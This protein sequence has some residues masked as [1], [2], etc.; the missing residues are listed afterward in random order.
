MPPRKRSTRKPVRQ[1]VSDEA[2]TQP[3]N[4]A[5]RRR[6]RGGGHVQGRR[7]RGG[8]IPEVE[9][10]RATRGNPVLA[11]LTANMQNM[12]ETLKVLVDVVGGQRQPQDGRPQ[13]GDEAS[14]EAVQLEQPLVQPTRVEVSLNA[15]TKLNP[16]TFSGSDIHED[17]QAFVE[18]V[19]WIC[20]GLDYSPTRMVQL[21]A[22]RLRDIA[23]G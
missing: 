7:R 18:E 5:P 14:Q 17:P 6:V 20:R 1:P 23:R 9:V 8:G 15:F 22:F 16:P 13:Q 2:S 19:S 10:P 21:A 3:Q 12:N 11:Q 4:D